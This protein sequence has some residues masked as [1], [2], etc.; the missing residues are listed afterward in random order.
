MASVACSGC[1]IHWY[2]AETGTSHVFGFG[3][4]KMRDST[5]LGTT[6][7]KAAAHEVETIGLG[8]AHDWNGTYLLAGWNASRRLLVADDVAV[9]L[10]GASPALFDLRVG[11]VPP[12]LA[13]PGAPS[14][15]DAPGDPAP[16][17]DV[18]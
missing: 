2:D 4:L 5:R 9:T 7:I 18:R 10:E 1:A 16:G 17:E 8:I 13:P 6:G 3:H 15:A 12:W 14:D 11:D